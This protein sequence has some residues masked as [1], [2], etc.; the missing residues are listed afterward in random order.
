M[1][2]GLGGL[3]GL[4]TLIGGGNTPSVNVGGGGG[5]SAAA[6]V[7]GP[8]TDILGTVG[9][10]GAQIG[11]AFIQGEYAKDIARIQANAP[12]SPAAPQAPIIIQQPAPAIPTATA[13][14]PAPS[15]PYPSASFPA[16]Q[17]VAF[18]GGFGG[19]PQQGGCSCGGV[20]SRSTPYGVPETGY[21]PFP[22]SMVPGWGTRDLVNARVGGIP[23][24]CRIY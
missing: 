17:P 19:V 14:Y 7:V 8:L 16:P 24:P 10:I 15:I 13:A 4:G 20:P 2:F 11:S 18:G 3:A 21:N 9:S 5:G 22:V 6:D 12:R 1:A 23:S